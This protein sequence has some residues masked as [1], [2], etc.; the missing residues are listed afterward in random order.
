MDK[1]IF[2][3]IDGVLNCIETFIQT[4]GFRKA[5]INF[6]KNNYNI[7]YLF[8]EQ[9][10]EIDFKKVMVLKEIIEKTNAKI[11]VTSAWRL[12]RTYPLIEEKLIEIGLPIIGVTKRLKNR[13]EEILDYINEH[14]IKEY[15]IIDDEIFDDFTEELKYNLVQTNFYNEGLTEEHIYDVYEKLGLKK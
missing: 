12:L 15:I 7:D 11:V 13:G 4:N 2:L 8:Q 10:L 9:M 3:D 14:E 5:Y 1:I 6:Y